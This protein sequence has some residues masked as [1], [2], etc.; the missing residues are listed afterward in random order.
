ML[1]GLEFML[2]CCHKYDLV[3]KKRECQ[4]F[5]ECPRKHSHNFCYL[6]IV[7]LSGVLSVK[8]YLRY[9]HKFYGP[10]LKIVCQQTAFLL[11]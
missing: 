9:K 6:M 7:L 11:C 3:W 5:E 2:K 8:L 1:Q 10:C 4:N